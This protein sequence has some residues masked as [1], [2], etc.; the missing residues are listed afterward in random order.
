MPPTESQSLADSQA[1]VRKH[2]D[3]QSEGLVRPDRLA[4]PAVLP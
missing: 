4:A 2:L 1:S 3:D